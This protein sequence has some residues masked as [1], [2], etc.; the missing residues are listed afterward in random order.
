[1]VATFAPAFRSEN[2]D[3]DMKLC[4]C[5]LVSLILSFSAC[6]KSEAPPLYPDYYGNWQY[7]GTNDGR[8]L[9]ISPSPDSTVVLSLN[10]PNLYSVWLNG[11]LAKSGSFQLDSGLGMITLQFN[12]LTQPYGSQT[13][14]STGGVT[15]LF[16]NYIQVGQL[17]LFQIDYTNAPGDTLNLLQGPVISPEAATNSFKRL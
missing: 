10:P 1:M 2:K 7:I 5:A 14:V 9:F 12:N 8:P 3:C 13:S 6:K 15:F 16:Y 17:T 4:L 11:V